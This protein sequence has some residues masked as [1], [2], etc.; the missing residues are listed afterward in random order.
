VLAQF[1]TRSTRPGGI[2]PA[3][4]APADAPAGRVPRLI[5][6]RHRNPRGFVHLQ[7]IESSKISAA[8]KTCLPGKR[9]P[10]SADPVIDS[11]SAMGCQ[12]RHSWC[13]RALAHER[14]RLAE[15]TLGHGAIWR[16]RTCVQTVYGP[17]MWCETFAM[18]FEKAR[19]RAAE[20]R[21]LAK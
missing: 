19:S 2:D 12:S 3:R 13:L 11:K 16:S 20:A 10:H 18:A 15:M 5:S 21:R 9:L 8:R 6:T 4:P 17:P 1:A 7:I 14:P